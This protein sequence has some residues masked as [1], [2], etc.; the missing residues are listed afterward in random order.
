V[1]RSGKISLVL[2]AVVLLWAGLAYDLTRPSDRRDYHRTVVQV[3][4]A[5]HDGVRTGWLVGR[6]RLAGQVFGT[7]GDAAF[8]DATDAVAGASRQFAQAA[9]PDGQ[10]AR[11]GDQL[12]PLLQDAVRLLADAA[13]A[14]D[15]NDLR[16]AVDGLGPLAER[17]DAFIEANR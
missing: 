11:L 2:A 1:R 5:A 15:D 17:L 12:R 3:A 16:A 14:T 13:R 7:F 9:P 10:S 8:G 6:Q 4:E